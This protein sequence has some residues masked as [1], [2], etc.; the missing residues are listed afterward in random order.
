MSERRVEL[1][2]VKELPAAA[3]RGDSPG[4]HQLADGAREDGV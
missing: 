1:L 2:A 3:V 4:G